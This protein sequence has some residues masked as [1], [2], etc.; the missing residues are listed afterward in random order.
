[1]SSATFVGSLHKRIC[2]FSPRIFVPS[3]VTAFCVDIRLTISLI[4]QNFIY[5]IF[6][7][8]EQQKVAQ[9]LAMSK[10]ITYLSVVKQNKR[11]STK[12]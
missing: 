10:K 3:V 12:D 2:T 6:K 5:N 8:P 1:M 7:V 11:F 9:N 4:P